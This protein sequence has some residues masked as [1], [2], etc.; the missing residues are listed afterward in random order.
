[1]RVLITAVLVLAGCAPSAPV[2][3]PSRD[4]VSAVAGRVAGEKRGCVPTIGRSGLMPIDTR[5]IAVDNGS[6][7]WVSHLPAECPGLRPLA[8]LIVERTGSQYCRGDLF[9]ATEPGL[10]IPG[11][12]CVLS[13]FTAYR[14]AR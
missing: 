8:T 11:P 10:S 12:K 5:T 4:F 13:E 3:N 2:E 14:K 7:L 1:M 9:R 6:I